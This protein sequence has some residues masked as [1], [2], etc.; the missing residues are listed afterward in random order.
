MIIQRGILEN[1]KNFQHVDIEL[2][3]RV[4][5]VGP[6]ASGKSN[7]L[8]VFRFMRDI[9]KQAGGLQFAV[10]ERGGVSKL[11]YI[12]ARRRTDIVIELHLNDDEDQPEPKWK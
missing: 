2:S 8:D 1:W 11:R 12:S 6:N 9:V 3:N 5:I 7:F 4:F 10:G